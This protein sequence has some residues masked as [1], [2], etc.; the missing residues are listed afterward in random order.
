M[1]I[2]LQMLLVNESVWSLKGKTTQHWFSY[3]Q[4]TQKY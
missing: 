3:F 2:L 4:I 1:Y